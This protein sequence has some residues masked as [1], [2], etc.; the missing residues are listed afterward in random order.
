VKRFVNGQE[1]E[2]SL[3]QSVEITA[4]ED[5]LIVKTKDGAQS[6]V[7]VRLGETVHV[8]YKGH[9]FVVERSVSRAGIH[10]AVAS[11]EIRA[12]MP[13]QVVDVFVKQGAKVFAGD[14]I[15]VLEA[16]KTQQTFASGFDGTVSKLDAK[17]GQQV[18]EGELLALIE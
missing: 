13:G 3:P 8:S 5:R 6:A 18:S 7:A 4:I 1:V 15:L 11:G 2:L 10:G 9:E 14:K 17:K 12:P 16:M